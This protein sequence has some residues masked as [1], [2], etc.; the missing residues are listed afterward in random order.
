[1]TEFLAPTGEVLQTVD[2]GLGCFWCAL[3]GPDGRM[4]CMVVADWSKG[5][6]MVTGEPTGWVLGLDVSVPC[7]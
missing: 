3:G 7:R 5:P 6:A 1:V 4:L 2:T